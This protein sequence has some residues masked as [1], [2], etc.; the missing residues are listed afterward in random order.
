MVGSGAWSVGGEVVGW[1]S[2]T[3]YTPV[4]QLGTSSKHGVCHACLLTTV[5]VGRQRWE[6]LIDLGLT[7]VSLCQKDKLK[8][9]VR[10]SCV[11]D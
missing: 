6:D 8:G 5:G 7:E 11:I 10:S 4:T 1:W 2:L 3:M 9:E